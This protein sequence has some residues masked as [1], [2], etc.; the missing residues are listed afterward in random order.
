MWHACGLAR[1]SSSYLP[2]FH[3][4]DAWYEYIRYEELI[5]N[6]VFSGIEWREFHFPDVL[7]TS[8]MSLP[9]AKVTEGKGRWSLRGDVARIH[10]LPKYI[11]KVEKCS[12]PTIGEY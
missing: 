4:F 3:P 8:C 11:S 6:R 5:G 2:F 1:V 10:L 12:F 7:G 9:N